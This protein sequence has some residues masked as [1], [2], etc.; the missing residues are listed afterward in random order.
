MRN[1]V[2]S[3]TLLGLAARGQ[4]PPQSR[5]QVVPRIIKL[6][7]LS[8]E[9]VSSAE[10]QIQGNPED[11]SLRL[12]LLAYYRDMAPVP[13]NDAPSNGWPALIQYFQEAQGL[14]NS[15][16]LSG[17][18]LM[19]PGAAMGAFIASENA[20]AALPGAPSKIRIGGNVQKAKLVAGPQPVYPE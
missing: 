2:L 13:P 5:P 8:P 17:R 12:R 14:S 6:P 1:S 16:V 15:Q 11:L 18:A 4:Q 7:A 20:N 19:R 3:A 10:A 9:D